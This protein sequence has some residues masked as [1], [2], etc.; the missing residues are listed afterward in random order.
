M[1]I[2]VKNFGLKNPSGYKN[3]KHCL[4]SIFDALYKVYDSQAGQLVLHIMK[5]TSRKLSALE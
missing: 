3:C 2:A 4:G 1:S 5:L